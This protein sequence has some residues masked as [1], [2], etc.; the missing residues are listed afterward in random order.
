[1]A[2]DTKKLERFVE[3]GIEDGLHMRP[4]MKLVD[5]A[6]G[7][8]SEITVSYN[9]LSVDGK[10]I[11]Q[12][13]MLAATKGTRLLIVAEGPDAAEALEALAAIIEHPE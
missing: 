12:V 3:V 2:A 6:N 11:M 10:S 5:R 13:T 7:F 8:R 9:D 1:M 4:A